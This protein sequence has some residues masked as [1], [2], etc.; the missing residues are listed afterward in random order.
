MD[1]KPDKNISQMSK[2]KLTYSKSC[3]KKALSSNGMFM[4][5]FL[6]I[7]ELKICLL[8]QITKTQT[9]S[10]L[11]STQVHFSDP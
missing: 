10:L 2:T 3:V 9:I 1:I 4:M 8:L 11:Y 6:L 5:R 7:H